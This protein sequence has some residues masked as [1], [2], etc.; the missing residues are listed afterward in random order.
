MNYAE[1]FNQGLLGRKIPHFPYTRRHCR[2]C[3]QELELVEAIHIEKEPEHYKGLY[4]CQNPKCGCFDE[5]SKSQ[6]VRVYY[7]SEQ[8]FRKLEVHRIYRN[9]D[10]KT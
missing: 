2:Y 10:K 6:Y 3:E 4:L 8:A 5:E 1:I 9:I 7:S